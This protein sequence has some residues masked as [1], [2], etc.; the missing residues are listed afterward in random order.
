MPEGGIGPE[1]RAES[2]ELRKEGG[3][4]CVLLVGVRGGSCINVNPNV[5][6]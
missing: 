4:F 6:I 1:S 5:Y 3:Q 2:R